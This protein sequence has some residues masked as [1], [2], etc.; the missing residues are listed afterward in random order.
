LWLHPLKGNQCRKRD[1]VI[2]PSIRFLAKAIGVSLIT[3]KK[4]IPVYAD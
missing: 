1:L 4:E 3:D 2:G